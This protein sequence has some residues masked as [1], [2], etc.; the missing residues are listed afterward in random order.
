MTAGIKHNRMNKKASKLVYR[1][2]PLP[3]SVFSYIWDYGS[4][5]KDEEFKYIEKIIGTLNDISLYKLQWQHI[6]TI[7]QT[8]HFSQ[9]FIKTHEAFWSV[10]LRDVA[11]FKKLYLFFE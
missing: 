2:H 1:V 8:I 10:S 3:E 11:R 4:L 9:H 6:S 7:V 5:N